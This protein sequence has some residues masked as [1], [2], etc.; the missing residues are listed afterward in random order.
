M[1][2]SKTILQAVMVGLSIGAASSCTLIE[3]V[4]EGELHACE[5]KCIEK[6]D[7]N[8]ADE[9]WDCPACGMG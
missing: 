9:T 5:D 1:K 7:L 2:V 4:S 6:C 8:K 3:E